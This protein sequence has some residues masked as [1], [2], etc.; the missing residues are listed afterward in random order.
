MTTPIQ[1]IFSLSVQDITVANPVYP[2]YDADGFWYDLTIKMV[3]PFTFCAYPVFVVISMML[4]STVQVRR[5]Q[6]V[7]HFLPFALANCH[8]NT[9]SSILA[10]FFSASS[11]SSFAKLNLEAC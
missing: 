11:F 7:G 1:T 8:R 3:R 10:A 9:H 4:I 6:P 2:Q 5:V